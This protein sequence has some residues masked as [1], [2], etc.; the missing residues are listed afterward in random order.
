M[1]GL[2]IVLYILAGL[3]LLMVLWALAGACVAQLS[4]GAM[5]IAVCRDFSRGQQLCRWH[6]WMVGAGLTRMPLVLVCQELTKKEQACL[7][8]LGAQLVDAG[9]LLDRLQ[10]EEQK[11]DPGRTGTADGN[12]GGSDLSKHQ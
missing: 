10:L 4:Q 9:A 2:T 5:T 6:R 3:G 7:E 1:D 12:R 11:N 8:R